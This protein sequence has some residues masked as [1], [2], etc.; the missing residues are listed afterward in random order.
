MTLGKHRREDLDKYRDVDIFG[1]RSTKYVNPKTGKRV[2][3][4]A[5]DTYRESD[6]NA[7]R[8]LCS[9][10]DGSSGGCSSE[11]CNSG[12]YITTACLDAMG[13]PRDSLEMR[14]MKTLTRKP[15]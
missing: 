14:A 10:S 8:E 15:I 12:C 5:G 9:S 13:F 7:E 11:G 4:G 3:E 1:I 6:R 2:A